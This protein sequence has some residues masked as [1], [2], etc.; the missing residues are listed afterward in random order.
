M[1]MNGQNIICN[2]F[3]KTVNRSN[4]LLCINSVS[5]YKDNP[6]VSIY[7]NVCL[8]RAALKRGMR[9]LGDVCRVLVISVV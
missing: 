5:S 8:N 3:L 4:F 2:I 9:I 1:N 7:V 6:S